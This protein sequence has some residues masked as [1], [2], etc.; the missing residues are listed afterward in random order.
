[1]R[2]TIEMIRLQRLPFYEMTGNH[3]SKRWPARWAKCG[4]TRDRA[5]I[6]RSPGAPNLANMLLVMRDDL[7]LGM[8]IKLEAAPRRYRGSRP[9]AWARTPR[10]QNNRQTHD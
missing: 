4:S 5:M 6:S 3:G 9:L 7:A 2:M 1:Q 10:E 8:V